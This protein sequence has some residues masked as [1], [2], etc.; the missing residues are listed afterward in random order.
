M[1]RLFLKVCQST[2]ARWLSLS[3]RE[4][5]HVHVLTLLSIGYVLHYLVF[6][7]YFIE[8]A[9]ISYSYAKHLVEGE[10][11]VAYPGGERVE[12]YSNPTWTLLIAVFY[13][14]KI[15]VWFSAKALGAVLGALT[16]PLSYL[17]V[18]E[19]RPDKEDGVPLLAPFFLAAST[20]F[21]VWNASGLENSLFNFLL[22]GGLLCVLREG[23]NSSARPFS[24]V[25]FVLLAMTRPEGILYAAIAGGFRLIMALR[26]GPVI[27]PILAWLAVFWVPFCL[28]HAWRFSYFGWEWPN[29]YYAKLDG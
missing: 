11:L 26:Q 9:G 27:R 19:C 25:C 10:G 14:L 17:L 2:A 8:D 15:P 1:K 22:A 3:D 13:A 23:R 4:R 20:T 21:V 29:T 6:S 18:R 5:I 12:G 16:L 28:Y 24:A 7:A